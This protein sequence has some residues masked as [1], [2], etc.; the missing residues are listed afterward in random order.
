[1]LS[2]VGVVLSCRVKLS[3][4]GSRQGSDLY[5]EVDCRQCLMSDSYIGV[6]SRHKVGSQTHI[7]G[8]VSDTVGYQ[9][10]SWM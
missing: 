6:N 8:P 1:M 7:W 5:L 10:Q 4:T 9:A 3:G 2:S